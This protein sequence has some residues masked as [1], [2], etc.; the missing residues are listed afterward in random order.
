MQRNYGMRPRLVVIEGRRK[1]VPINSAF[2]AV[3]TFF[4]WWIAVTGVLYLMTR[5]F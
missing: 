5:L 3:L 1:S 2:Q 4:G